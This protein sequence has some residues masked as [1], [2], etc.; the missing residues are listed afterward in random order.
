MSWRVCDERQQVSWCVWG[1]GGHQYACAIASKGKQLAGPLTYAS[2][3]DPAISSIISH[4]CWAFVNSSSPGCVNPCQTARSRAACGSGGKCGWVGV[5]WRGTAQ[6]ESSIEVHISARAE[7]AGS[8]NDARGC[9]DQHSQKQGA[10]TTNAS[11]ICFTL[12]PI[13]PI[14]CS[15]M[16]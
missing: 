4:R 9:D 5:Q 3:S 6:K 7:R 13:A 10:H 14:A 11:T 8:S 16:T 12:R 1:G 15:M 2:G